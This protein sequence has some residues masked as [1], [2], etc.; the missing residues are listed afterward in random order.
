MIT[1]AILN[2]Y[3]VSELRTMARAK[4]MRIEDKIKKN[5]LVEK[6]L[7][8][9]NRDK[10]SDVPKKTWT[11]TAGPPAEQRTILN[12]FNLYGGTAPA[13]A[14]APAVVAPPVESAID[15]RDRLIREFQTG[16]NVRL[17]GMTPRPYRTPQQRDE[18]QMEREY[19]REQDR[20][21]PGIPRDGPNPN[22]KAFL[23]MARFHEGS[24]TIFK[25]PVKRRNYDW[26]KFK[27]IREDWLYAMKFDFIKAYNYH[28][29]EINYDE[30]SNDLTRAEL[31]DHKEWLI[32]HTKTL[33]FIDT[34]ISVFNNR[35][36]LDP[37]R[38]LRMVGTT[39]YNYGEIT[40]DPFDFPD[41]GNSLYARTSLWNLRFLK[42]DLT[43]KREDGTSRGWG[44]DHPAHRQL[45]SQIDHLFSVIHRR[46]QRRV[47]DDDE[48]PH[49]E[50]MRAPIQ[51][52]VGTPEEHAERGLEELNRQRREGQDRLFA[53][54][55]RNS[56]VLHPTLR[57]G[58]QSLRR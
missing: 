50:V 41:W 32:R 54:G 13:P 24:H 58:G 53:T 20:M 18:E 33:A 31:R 34:R 28:K 44:R 1:K 43:T 45:T 12:R 16:L 14:P 4:Q 38:N 52:S 46:E 37:N 21:R 49:A 35:R 19:Q 36:E 27:E 22:N 8:E 39:E 55:N 10:F 5:V 9:T 51:A 26:A 11:T 48:Y 6:M 3:L 47:G 23:Q 56:T 2:S 30:H 25:N 7:K 15:R 17:D 29:Q 42:D 40:V 57:F